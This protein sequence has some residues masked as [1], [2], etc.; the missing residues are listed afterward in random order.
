MALCRGSQS[1]GAA[2]IGNNLVRGL[3]RDDRQR[4]YA[5]LEPCEGNEGVVYESG[6][7]VT[8]GHFPCDRAMASLRVVPADG[9][10]VEIALVDLEG[11]IGGVVSEGSL[12]RLP[13]CANLST[14]GIQY[15]AFD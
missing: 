2:D 12:R 14:G 8:H 15:S 5:G 11:A 4:L 10:S 9:R 6:D 1:I 13:V 7:I 3:R